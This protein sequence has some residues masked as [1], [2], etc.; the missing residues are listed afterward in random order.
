MLRWRVLSSSPIGVHR[1]GNIVTPPSGID[2]LSTEADHCPFRFY[3]TRSA[4][5]VPRTRWRATSASERVF[6]ARPRRAGGSHCPFGR[7]TTHSKPCN[8]LKILADLRKASLPKWQRGAMAPGQSGTLQ[9]LPLAM[10]PLI[11]L[12]HDGVKA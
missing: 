1:F 11:A 9:Q 5:R 6:R 10:K 4:N 12:A 2:S 8:A 7:G 3:P